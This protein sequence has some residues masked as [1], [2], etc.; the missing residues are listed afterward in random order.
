MLKTWNDERSIK[1][2]H[3]KRVSLSF[4]FEK[5][6]KRLR[7]L[8][9]LDW[10]NKK[11]IENVPKNSKSLR[12]MKAIVER[13]YLD[14]NAKTRDHLIEWDI[15]PPTLGPGRWATKGQSRRVPSL[16]ER[17]VWRQRQCR[18]SATSPNYSHAGVGARGGGFQT[19]RPVGMTE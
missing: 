6:K 2:L 5:K 7:K 17:C 10:S 8:R 18:T 11:C 19:F 4:I 16:F 14:R 1:S 3:F 12:V 15:Y 9:L 13:R